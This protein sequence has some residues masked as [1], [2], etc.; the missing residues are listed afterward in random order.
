M[1]RCWVV[2]NRIIQL[3]MVV[4]NKIIEQK[5]KCSLVK[6]TFDLKRDICRIYERKI[7]S[8]HGLKM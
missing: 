3:L 2:K 7:H 1:L 5:G 8:C 6:N 4:K